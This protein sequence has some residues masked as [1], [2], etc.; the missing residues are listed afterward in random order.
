MRVLT[1]PQIKIFHANLFK[2]VFID[3]NQL[4]DPLNDVQTSFGGKAAP[5][6][7]H[8]QTPDPLCINPC[9]RVKIERTTTGNVKN[10]VQA[11]RDEELS[12]MREKLK[13]QFAVVDASQIKSWETLLSNSIMNSLIRCSLKD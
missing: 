8:R 2:H 4:P 1:N 7:H 11:L 3:L 9:T 10:F 5:P 6:N 13:C 12:E